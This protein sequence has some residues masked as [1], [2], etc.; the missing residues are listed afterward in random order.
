MS[1]HLVMQ[2]DSFRTQI[3]VARDTGLPIIVHARDADDDMIE[4]LTDEMQ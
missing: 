1:M 2:A 4:I 3:A